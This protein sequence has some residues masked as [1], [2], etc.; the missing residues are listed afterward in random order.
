[1]VGLGRTVYG[2][3]QL[4]EFRANILGVLK[5]VIAPGRDLILAKLEGGPLATAGVMQGM[6]GSP[7]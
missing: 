4:D 6:S 1:M 3:E 5:N 7:V 2:G